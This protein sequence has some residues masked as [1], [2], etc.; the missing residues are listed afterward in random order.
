MSGL[1]EIIVQDAE[2]LAEKV[3]VLGAAEEVDAVVS[4]LRAHLRRIDR[5]RRRASLKDAI[6]EFQS[7]MIRSPVS[8]K[9]VQDELYD[10]YGLPK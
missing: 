1:P 4:V 10:E 3:A 2:R 6:E 9:E 8:S 7:T 5:E